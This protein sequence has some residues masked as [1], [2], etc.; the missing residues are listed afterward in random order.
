[1]D[2]YYEIDDALLDDMIGNLDLEED[3][4]DSDNEM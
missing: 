3:I 1:M 2:S 4:S